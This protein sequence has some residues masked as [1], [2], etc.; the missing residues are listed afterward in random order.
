MVKNQ[1]KIYV[2]IKQVI[3]YIAEGKL[4]IAQRKLGIAEQIQ[5]PRFILDAF[6]SLVAIHEPDQ[7]SPACFGSVDSHRM[8][9]HPHSH[10]AKI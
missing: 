6:L 8:D 9:S 5:P 7:G 2:C 4:G 3:I 10:K 1:L